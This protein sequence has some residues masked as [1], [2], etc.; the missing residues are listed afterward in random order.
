MER[1]AGPVPRLESVHGSAD[2]VGMRP[3]PWR[4][5][6][7]DDLTRMLLLMI[8]CPVLFMA[9]IWIGDYV[10]DMRLAGVDSGTYWGCLAPAATPKDIVNKVSAALHTVVQSA[11]VKPRLEERGYTVIG[12]APERFG[13]NIRSEIAKW[14]KV[15]KAANIKV[16]AQQ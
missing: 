14:A 16:E 7:Q 5:R 15:I 12:S 9:G 1:G 8:L 2:D 10:P 11:E 6:V 3:L 13:E 4:L